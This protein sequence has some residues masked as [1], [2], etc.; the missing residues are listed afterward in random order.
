[1]QSNVDK[2]LHSHVRDHN[3]VDVIG[4]VQLKMLRLKVAAKVQG[5]K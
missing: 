2:I 5:N 4:F 3:Q 1:M